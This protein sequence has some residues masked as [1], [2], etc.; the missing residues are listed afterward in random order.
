MFF[1][2]PDADITNLLMLCN[3]RSK[4]E[5]E[6]LCRSLTIRQRD[7][8][9][10]VVYAQSGVFD[11]YKYA[12]AFRDR[13]PPNLI[14][15]AKE[16]AAISASGIGRP[17]QHKAKK[18]FDKMSQMFRDKRALAAHLIYTLDHAHWSLFYCDQ[19]DTRAADNHW[20]HGPHLHFVSSI[21]IRLDAATVY[22]QVTHGKC[23]FPA[24]HIR[25]QTQG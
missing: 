22:Q 11:P 8:V 2:S 12:C 19:R 16:R 5:V 23:R 20:E 13:Q 14:P 1:L 21:W 4:S 7:F 10:F 9:T 3:L 18:A 6:K 25:F 24:V 15:T 17:L